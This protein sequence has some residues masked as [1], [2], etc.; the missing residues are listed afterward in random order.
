MTTKLAAVSMSV[1]RP[2]II[3]L[4]L[5]LG[6]FWPMAQARADW[7]EFRGPWGDGHVSAPG[8]SKPI[9][10]P[11]NW[12]ETGNVK[13]KIEIP[14][15][16]WSTPV[17]MDGQVWLTT[18]TEDGHDFFV[19]CVDAG[20][21]KVRLN[22]KLFHCD[23]PEPLGNI[24]NGYA[25]PSAAIE[26]GR[27]YVHFGC[28]GTACLD[29]A[30]GKVLW[31]RQDLP[32]RHYRGPASSLILFENLLILTMDGADVQYHAALD[33]QTGKTV[34]KTN[35]SVKFNDA[36][37]F[38]KFAKDGDLR[39]AH[40][41]PLIVSV[42]GQ[43]QMLSPGAKAAYAYDPRTGRELW[44]VRHGCWSAAPCPL[45]SQGMA[46]FVTGSGTTEVW[47]VRVGGQGDVTDSHVAWK[48]GNSVPRT[49]SPVIVGDL[50][51]MVSDDSVVTCLEVA[52]GKEVWR[53]RIGGKYASSPIYA[54]GRLYFFN[55]QGKTTV[56]KPGRTF[57]VLATN[58][59]DIGCMASPAVS[60][61][62]LFLRTKTHLYRIE[63]DSA[64]AAP[65]AKP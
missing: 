38:Q 36:E 17:V 59:L 57:E 11:L 12:S 9:G 41:T 52:T 25:T 54:D 30:T 27:V 53:E 48:F 40:S 15:R 28:Y 35:R 50:L 47:A 62:A 60:G 5:L 32:C 7:P 58:T 44:M 46:L 21:G 24:V 20:T 61:K 45:F 55:Q 51:Y 8:D 49:A 37:G 4:L 13:W 18:A 10:L 34:W 29:S 19:I 1:L 16:G 23:N 65:K 26:K 22:Q 56:L 43:P 64:A 63:G 42:N 33:K 2:T 39:K 3:G 31:Q 6:S 14:F